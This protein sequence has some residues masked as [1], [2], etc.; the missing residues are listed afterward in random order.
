MAAFETVIRTAALGPGTIAEVYA[1]GREIALANV[2][3]T[4]YAV[5]ARCP[6]D[7]TNLARDGRLDGELLICPN[8]DARF[9][10]RT[11][12]RIG[13]EGEL[14][15]RPI[16]VEGNEVRVGPPANGG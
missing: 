4:Y 6:V 13:G 16:R 5:D 2:G 8:D 3:Q 9:D 14:E 15:A 12:R 1:H 11:G 10:I 7:G